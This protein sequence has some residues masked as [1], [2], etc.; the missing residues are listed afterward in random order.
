MTRQDQDRPSKARGTAGRPSF[1]R[2]QADRGAL[3]VT[4][5]AS[6]AR[7]LPTYSQFCFQL[8][9]PPRPRSF[10]ELFSKFETCRNVYCDTGAADVTGAVNEELG[11]DEAEPRKE[12]GSSRERVAITVKKWARWQDW[13]ALVAGVYA[14]LSPL[15]TTT[16]AVASGTLILLGIV[17]AVVALAALAE[18]EAMVVQW[19]MAA[20]GVVVFISPWVLSFASTTGMAWAA[21]I[22]GAVALVA[23]LWA[24]PASSKAHNQ[25]LAAQR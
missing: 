8:Q 13:V 2:S 7:T 14:I 12:R 6:S 9:P 20:V 4:R 16:V 3:P 21:W 24:L 19:L 22:V 17:I 18:P 10:T 11:S 1:R 15:W 5:Y 25:L 23:G